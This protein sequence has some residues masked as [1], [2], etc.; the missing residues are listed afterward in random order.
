MQELARDGSNSILP[1]VF[2]ARLAI[3]RTPIA[4]SPG[5]ALKAAKAQGTPLFNTKIEFGS[6]P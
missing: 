4:T 6:H 1:T 2:T 3:S 5:P